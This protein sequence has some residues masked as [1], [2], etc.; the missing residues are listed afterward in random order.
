MYKYAPDNL[1]YGF[2]PRTLALFLQQPES[3]DSSSSGFAISAPVIS[4]TV[5][6]TT[7]ASADHSPMSTNS[8]D[9][10][11]N[12]PPASIVKPTVTAKELSAM[13]KESLAGIIA[14]ML[15]KYSARK[16][17]TAAHLHNLYGSHQNTLLIGV[18]LEKEF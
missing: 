14:G 7:A 5:Q 17:V 1:G 18:L 10:N 8:A 4:C 12:V 2:P 11:S 13:R 16:E 3:D 9:V 15:H 6:T